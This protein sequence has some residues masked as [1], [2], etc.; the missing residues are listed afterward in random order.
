M[1][2][3]IV[4]LGGNGY[5][6]RELTRQWHA[7]DAEAEFWVL[8]RSGKNQLDLPVIHNYAVD[9]TD[10]AAVEAVL[11]TQVDYIV[12]LV[13]R[14]E[15]DAELSKQIND[16]PAMV[17]Q[18][19]AEERQICAI[20]FIGGKLGPKAFLATKQRLIDQLSTSK[21]PLAYVEP[22]VVYGADRDDQIAKMVPLLRFA[23]LFAKNIRPV[24]VSVVAKKLLDSLLVAGMCTDAKR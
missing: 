17:M 22:T 2:L 7:Q 1:T 19:L 11:P 8:S 15:K 23:G 6:G 21:I 13:G 18:A 5:I 14:P 20:G 12:D 9:V 24:E 16:A 4:L 10:Q 3:N